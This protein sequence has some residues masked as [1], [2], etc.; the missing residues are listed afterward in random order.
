[1]VYRRIHNP[2]MAKSSW[3]FLWMR[4][5]TFGLFSD[6]DKTLVPDNF[7]GTILHF[8]KIN[9]GLHNGLGRI[10][11]KF[12]F[13]VTWKNLLSTKKVIQFK[14]HKHEIFLNF[15]WPKSNPYMP[16][17]NFRKRFR[18]V[19]FDFRQNFEVRTFTRWLSIRGT[20]FFWEIS[21]NLF[22]SKSSLW[23]Y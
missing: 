6:Y 15:F 23:S 8:E 14:V 11:Y 20:K 21:K 18:L 1:M 16:L 13:S 9:E 4:L 7:K 3:C 5:N 19:S 17:V 2:Y 10:A 12:Y 22:S